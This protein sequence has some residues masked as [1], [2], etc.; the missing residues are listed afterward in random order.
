ME[1]VWSVPACARANG[2]AR[3]ACQ[4]MLYNSLVDRKVPFVPVAGPD[5]KQVTWYTCGPTVYD[6]AH[7]GHARNYVSFDILRRVLEDYFGYNIKFIMNVTDVEDK[8]I[9]RARRNYLLRQYD[10]ASRD[11]AQVGLPGRRPAGREDVA[12]AAVAA[13]ACR[14][15]PPPLKGV[16]GCERRRRGGHCP[17]AHQGRG[18]GRRARRGARAGRRPRQQ[19]EPQRKL[20]AG[21]PWGGWWWWGV[22]VCVVGVG[23]VGG[24]GSCPLAPLACTARRLAGQGQQE[25]AYAGGPS[26]LPCPAAAP[27]R[28]GEELASA[29]AQEQLLLSKVEASAAQLAAAGPGAGAQAL[30][31]LGGDELA[32]ALDAQHGAEVTDP[33]IFRSHAAK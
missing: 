18:R 29:L 23:G 17:A 6:S 30:L 26:N 28:V 9:L 7:M 11:A 19:G 2:D 31:A 16:C 15:L 21:L 22:C 1:R 10:A 13:D 5:S 27:Q 14:P 4:L 33:A 8:I 32:V 3:A 25:A 20:R 24:P 12:A